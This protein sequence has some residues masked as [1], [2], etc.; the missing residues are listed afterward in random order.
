MS[1]F[2]HLTVIFR[3]AKTE[4]ESEQVPGAFPWV[5]SSNVGGGKYS[6]LMGF[7]YGGIV[8]SPILRQF[9]FE[10]VSLSS[11]EQ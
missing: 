3:R 5:V 10:R 8:S 11:Q 2:A 7:F 6:V 4:N 9:T 1:E